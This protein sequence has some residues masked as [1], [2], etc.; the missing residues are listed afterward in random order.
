[1]RVP[2]P[3]RQS[4]ELRS[5]RNDKHP[6]R[7][8]SMERNPEKNAQPN[9]QPPFDDAIIP[10]VIA[11]P[12][13]YSNDFEEGVALAEEYILLRTAT[14]MVNGKLQAWYLRTGRT[15][16]S[17]GG[18]GKVFILPEKAAYKLDRKLLLA[19][20]QKQLGLSP[21]RAQNV[22][23]K[24]SRPEIYKGYARYL[25]SRSAGGNETEN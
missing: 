14:E 10:D 25:P 15:E 21:A 5:F 12:R 17:L 6:R 8:S 18:Q 11:Q 13:P 2:Q 9:A 1:M 7:S 22:V 24:G 16:I 20:L 19:A 4:S 3:V 23:D